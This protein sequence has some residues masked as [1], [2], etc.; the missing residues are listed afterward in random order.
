MIAVLTRMNSFLRK[1]TVV[2]KGIYSIIFSFI[3][4]DDNWKCVINVDALLLETPIFKLSDVVH[5]VGKLV[6]LN[7]KRMKLKEK[8]GSKPRLNKEMS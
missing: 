1:S 7:M 5:V 8:E 6:C 2:P 3:W 4:R